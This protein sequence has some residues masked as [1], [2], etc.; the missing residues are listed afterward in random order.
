MSFWKMRTID[1]ISF[2]EDVLLQPCYL[3]VLTFATVHVV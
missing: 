2:L 1:L 3:Y